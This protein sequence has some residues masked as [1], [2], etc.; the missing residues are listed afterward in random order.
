M[1]EGVPAFPAK[2][3]PLRDDDPERVGGYE[4]TGFLGE[5]G[6][7]SV[8]LGRGPAGP[9]AV[10][11]VRADHARN[12]HFRERFRREAASALRVP[13]FCTAEVLDADPD[14]DPPYLVTEYIDGPTLDEA[15]GGG[16]PLRRAELEQLGVSMAA[17]LTGIHGAGVVHRDLK[18]GNVLLSRMGP[19][20]IDFGIAS[21][22]DSA[23]G[24]TATGQI[25][26]TPAYMAPEQLEG[27][28]ATA[29]GDV[30]AWG[31]VMAFAATGRRAFGTGPAQAVAYRI[32]HG[33]PDLEGIEEP[34]RT[35]IAEA[36]AKDPARR[37]T[38]HD[39]LARLGVAG[40]D[41]AARPGAGV[42]AGVPAGG[43]AGGTA[44]RQGPGGPDGAGGSRE[45]GF[46]TPTQPPPS[47]AGPESR[48][49]PG[50]APAGAFA[51]RRGILAGVLAVGGAVLAVAVLAAVVVPQLLR[52]GDGG[53]T[54]PPSTSTTTGGGAGG[55]DLAGHYTSDYGDMYV[56]VTG[57]DVWMVYKWMG[58][59]RVRGVLDGTVIDG[60]YSEGSG[61]APDG[62]VRFTV[63]R[64][65]SGVALEGRWGEDGALNSAW[66]ARR[67]D[68]AVPADMAARL[69]DPALFPSPPR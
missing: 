4:V 9:V 14:A 13:R 22:L 23:F 39:L 59:S 19:R 41:T 69:R 24:L 45:P 52:G 28:S 1:S 17:A 62:R 50:A 55:A 11:V 65:G 40:G 37:P 29:A 20:V 6:M 15:V 36:L 2:A 66:N 25:V 7:G 54:P 30:F 18:P 31:A 67:V 63:R 3:R 33:D 56:R 27:E 60:H 32:V 64:S 34:L 26:G 47:P 35:V 21:A 44:G 68:G 48:P 49:V 43:T 57:R 16:G 12:P 10:K 42:P 51:G 61:N 53:G 8:Y 58:L 38:A 46:P 5:G